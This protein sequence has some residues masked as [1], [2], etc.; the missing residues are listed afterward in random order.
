[1]IVQAKNV[2]QTEMVKQEVMASSCYTKNWVWNYLNKIDRKKLVENSS[3]GNGSKHRVN[4]S[5]TTNHET[6]L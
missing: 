6:G 2:D 4:A 5:S 1:M 3:G